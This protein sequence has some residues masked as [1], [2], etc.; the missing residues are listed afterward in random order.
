MDPEELFGP[1]GQPHAPELF[2]TPDGKEHY[3]SYLQKKEMYKDKPQTPAVIPKTQGKENKHE[4]CNCVFR[5]FAPFSH[6]QKL[7]HPHSATKLLRSK[8]GRVRKR[9]KPRVRRLKHLRPTLPDAQAVSL[10][11]QGSDDAKAATDVEDTEPKVS[12]TE[13]EARGGRRSK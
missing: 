1:G 13:D 6:H 4:C 9:G 12:E 3:Y 5:F 10:I 11:E 8:T 2:K 7:V